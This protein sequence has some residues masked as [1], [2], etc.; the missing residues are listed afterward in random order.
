MLEKEIDLVQGCINR[1]AQNSFVVKGWLITLVTVILALLPDKIN[2]DFLCG[3]II[4]T[5][6]L[7]WY[8]DA[9][10]LRTEKLYRWKY[11]WIIA[12]RT[13]DD[14]FMYD[15][16]PYNKNMWKEAKKPSIL[17]VMF[18]KTL[19]PLYGVIIILAVLIIF[20][21]H[22]NFISLLNSVEQQSTDTQ[23]YFF[24]FIKQ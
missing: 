20:N 15:L 23:N 12:N 2:I 10:F 22:C 8:L 24:S 4:L 13:K 14:K 7:F 3:V 19:C 6:L 21:N 9:F 17:R 18:T 16:N 11:E 1:M 5:T